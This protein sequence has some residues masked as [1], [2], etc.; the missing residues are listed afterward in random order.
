MA[1][2]VLHHFDWS[3]YGEKVRVLLGIKGLAWRSV[4]IPMVMPKPDLT[5]LTGGYRKTP[6]L[7]VGADVYCDTS[8]IARELERRCPE[9]TFFPD[10]GRGQALALAPWAERFFDSGAGLSMGLADQLPAELLQDRREFFSHMDFDRFAARTPHMFGQ[11]LANAA[12]VEE[13][14][15][16]GR[17]FLTADRP[18]LADASA[19]YVLWM[20]RGFV[21]ALEPMLVPFTRVAA[22][23]ARM[24]ALGHGERSEMDAADAIALARAAQPLPA[25]GV[26]P[27]DPAGLAAG[28]RVTVTPDDYG[29]VP[30]AGELVT[31]NLHEVA[32]RRRDERA[33]EVVVHFPRLGY[34]VAP[35]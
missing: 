24:R 15:A 27:G 25:A 8:L 29:K 10:G 16:D 3:P 1:D 22:W 13:Q 32:V 20:C 35:A 7:Q 14:L 21:P 11:V 12:L 28:Q 18:G 2:L 26:A 23:E 17:A 19:Y 9:P 5:A 31:L 6:V 33:G 30:V 34:V 4:Q